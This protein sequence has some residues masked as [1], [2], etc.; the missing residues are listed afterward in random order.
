M[1]KKFG[2]SSSTLHCIGM[3]TMLCDHLWVT[4]VPGNAWMHFV[5]RLAFPIFA[6]LLVEGYFKTKSLKR[7]GLRLLLFAMLSELPSNYIFAGSLFYPLHQNTI[8]TLL[9]GLCLIH[10][11]EK[12][13]ERENYLITASAGLFTIVLG[14]FLGIA[15]FVDYNGP[16]ILTILVFYFFRGNRWWLRT[17]QMLLL[18]YINIELLS[19]LYYPIVVFGYTIPL[20]VQGAAL[21]S[22]IPIWLYN[23]EKGVS[24]PW[25]RIFNYAFYPGHLILLSIIVFFLSF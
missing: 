2:L 5:G 8:W 10:I 12:A 1:K 9:L 6:F 20:V 4:I 15:T 16:G 23:G 21:F 18:A 11:N 24:A 13:K 17:I 25:F 7:Y 14:Y 22:L 19:G 3:L